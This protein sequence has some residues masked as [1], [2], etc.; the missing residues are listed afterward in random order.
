MKIL[1]IEDDPGVAEL[2]QRGLQEQKID[3]ALARDGVTGRDLIFQ[4]EFDLLI[5]DIILPG[6]NGIE[7]CRQVRQQYPHLPILM[8]TALGTTDDKLEGFDAG[9]DDYL[10]KPF[11]CRELNARIKALLKRRKS[12]KQDDGHLL[13]INYLEMDLPFIFTRFGA[14]PATASAPLIISIADISVVLI[15]FSIASYFFSL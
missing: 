9:A 12:D 11:D 14:D 7:L 10:V 8:L 6:I 13:N 4:K 3:T 1:I 2:I 15:Y 5:V